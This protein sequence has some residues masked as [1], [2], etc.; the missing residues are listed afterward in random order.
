MAWDLTGNS[1]TNPATNFLGTIDKQPLTIKTNGT[2]RLRVDE[3]GEVRILSGGGLE[4][5]GDIVAQNIIK[6][7]VMMA[8]LITIGLPPFFGDMALEVKGRIRL[9][10]GVGGA[11]AGTAGLWPHN[12][13]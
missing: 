5:S 10:D 9:Q 2:E 12:P 1:G 4:V 13:Q 7:S 8:D 11:A 6:G 3:N